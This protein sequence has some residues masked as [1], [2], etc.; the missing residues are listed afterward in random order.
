MRK[1]AQIALRHTKMYRYIHLGI[2]TGLKPFEI[3]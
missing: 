1:T 3:K 2:G